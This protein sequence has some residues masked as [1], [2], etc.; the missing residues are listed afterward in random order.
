MGKKI[1]FMYGETDVNGQ[2]KALFSNNMQ[3][4]SEYAGAEIPV[5]AVYLI[6]EDRAGDDMRVMV[7]ETADRDFIAT[8]SNTFIDSAVTL[9]RWAKDNSVNVESIKVVSNTSKKGRVFIM[10]EPL[11]IDIKEN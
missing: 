5:K 6:E 9:F 4:M 3:K 8:I 11:G 10:C 2:V 7:V 1:S